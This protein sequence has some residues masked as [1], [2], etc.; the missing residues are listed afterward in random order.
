MCQGNVVKKNR[1]QADLAGRPVFQFLQTEHH[2]LAK[3]YHKQRNLHRRPGEQL[4]E[5]S[6]AKPTPTVQ[7]SW[8]PMCG[9][10]RPNT[11]GG[12]TPGACSP[13]QRSFKTLDL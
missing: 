9:S 2:L 11:Q 13:H 7:H 12:G 10:S 6:K 5:V 4:S 3:G 1:Q 8:N